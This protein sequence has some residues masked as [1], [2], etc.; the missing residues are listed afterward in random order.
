MAL[1]ICRGARPSES[2]EF[3]VG[4]RQTRKTLA[5]EIQ[6]S[7]SEHSILWTKTINFVQGFGTGKEKR[8]MNN[9]GRAA[10]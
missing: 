6:S 9:L 5:E 4:L 3:C 8:A 10:C 2:V 7:L 1:N